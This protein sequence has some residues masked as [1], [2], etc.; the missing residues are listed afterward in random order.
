MADGGQAVGN[1]GGGGEV[2]EQAADELIRAYYPALMGSADAARAR[3]QAGYTI[4]SAVAAAIVA[5]GVFGDFQNAATIVRV[6]GSIALG[7]WLLTAILFIRAVTGPIQWP[8]KEVEGID[9]FSKTVASFASNARSRV[10]HRNARAQVATVLAVVLTAAA[11]FAAVLNPH[12]NTAAEANVLLSPTGVAAVSRL[13][14]HHTNVIRGA[15]EPE[16]L[17]KSAIQLT[18]APGQCGTKKTVLNLLGSYVLAIARQ[19]DPAT[20]A[21]QSSRVQVELTAR[22]REALRKQLG[23]RCREDDLRGLV[24]GGSRSAPTVL[25]FAR[26][27]C[28]RLRV[29]VT[30]G[31]GSVYYLPGSMQ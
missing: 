8:T 31:L 4:A 9:E 1:G 21:T 3:A 15:I 6:L 22:G 27:D 16:A 29:R 7:L 13:C 20:A 11:I 10:E 17:A 18:T 23:E 28:R 25:A 2:D 30:R 14:S 26:A 12:R 19:G 24:V 5:A